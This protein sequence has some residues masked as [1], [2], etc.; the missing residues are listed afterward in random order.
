MVAVGP[1]SGCSIVVAAA[2]VVAVVE[3]DSG[4]YS[5]IVAGIDEFRES[6]ALESFVYCV[7]S[8]CRPSTYLNIAGAGSL[9]V[10][11]AKRSFDVERCLVS[12]EFD[13]FAAFEV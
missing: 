2:V 10:A 8:G 6:V 12:V 5:D 3:L 9:V 11:F 13:D 7:H 4:D 1:D